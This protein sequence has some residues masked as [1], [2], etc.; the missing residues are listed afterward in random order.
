MNEQTARIEKIQRTVQR[1]PIG[2]VASYGQIAELSGLP[3]RA[4]LVGKSLGRGPSTQALPWQ[5][6][7]R[8]NGQI[9]FE[10]TSES[11]RKQR[12]FLEQE[13]VEVKNNRVNMKKFQW[14]PTLDEFFALGISAL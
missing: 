5:R 3:G 1:I 7:L 6:V 13:G 9:A 2:K 4:R 10:E 14:Q 8:S 12:Q 11:A